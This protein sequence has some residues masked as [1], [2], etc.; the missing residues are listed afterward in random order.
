MLEKKRIFLF[1]DG[2]VGGGAQRQLVYLARGL[3]E[4]GYTVRCFTIFEEGK[5]S[6]YRPFMDNNGIEHIC[7]TK[8]QNK[9]R[10]LYRLWK[11][12]KEFKPDVVIAY[13]SLQSTYAAICRILGHFT[14]ISSDRNTTQVMDK[15][16]Q[17]KFFFYRFA[18]Y[19]VPN[20]HSQGAFISNYSKHLSKKVRVITNLVDV[21]RFRP[22]P[23]MKL[24]DV[25]PHV[26]SV[27][28]YSS[29]KNYLGYID[30][31]RILKDKNVRV[32]FDWYGN[33]YADGY[34]VKMKEKIT[35]YG[36][37]DIITLHVACQDIENKYS[38]C[39][40]FCLPSFYEGFPNVLCEAMACGLP[41]VCSNVCDNPYIVKEGEN[42]YLCD[43]N[44]PMSIAEAIERVLA[45]GKEEEKR[46]SRANIDR[47]A[48]ICSEKAFVS[49][50]EA[51]F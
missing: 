2:L 40:A 45:L 29:Q 25:V 7:D 6:F 51:L 14:L 42:G 21:E 33:E 37:E 15:Y 18:D 32:H 19:I 26:I 9:I 3:K 10:R 47:I 4:R 5:W 43:P 27:G 13:G 44:N 41:V 49:K 38:E 11:A 20:S 8:A 31:V 16:E 48:E 12:I 35:E 28:R 30:A 34:S 24:N 36:L 1:I 46:M 17:L 50:Y 39:D 22:Q 23:E